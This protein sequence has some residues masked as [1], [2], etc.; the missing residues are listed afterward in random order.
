MTQ[1]VSVICTVLNEGQAIKRLLNSLVAQ[2]RLPDEIVFVDGGSTD[3]T[4][5]TLKNFTRLPIKVM[6][7]AGAN[8]SRGRNIAIEA[9]AGPI[10]ASTDAGVRLDPHW[11]EELLKPFEADHAPAVVAGF[12]VP[13]PQSAFEVAMGA[14][15]LPRVS[16][17]NPATFLPSSRS[18][19]F[20]KSAWQAA[21]G[22]PEWLDFCE[23][24]IFDF[25]LRDETG[26]FAFAP[27]A[28][29][30]FQP[31]SSLRAFFKQYYQYSR[32]DGKADLW[33]KRHAI[34][35]ITY[36]VALPLLVVL[37]AVLS[38]WWWLVGALIGAV[39][40][41]LTPYRRLVG[42]W[43]SLPATGKFV[44][45]LWVPVIRVAGDIAKMIGY[46]VGWKW[47]LQRLS[48]RPELRWQR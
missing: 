17:I 44:A 32:G 28:V 6:V 25:R 16:D 10:I 19:A 9:A 21:G 45:F 1:Q 48:S 26:P 43:A 30:Y 29:A 27:Q 14:T 36:L 40:M 34:R 13:D 7:E 38:P 23:D 22:Y 35:Y 31:R 39:G 18:V 15:V 8:I 11:L 3:D 41:L 42:Q 4:V 2:T 12:F 5:E 20:R 24:L 37:G 47:R 33:R 46:P